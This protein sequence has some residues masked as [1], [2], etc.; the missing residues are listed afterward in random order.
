MKKILIILLS[1][2][3]LIGCKK[4]EKIE[5]DPEIAKY[6]MGLALEKAQEIYNLQQKYTCADISNLTI[7]YISERYAC[8]EYLFIHK[9]DL[10]SF[11]NLKK[12]YESRVK[13][14]W[15]AGGVLVTYQACASTDVER[16]IICQ[17]NKPTIMIKQ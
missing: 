7:Q 5:K 1:S 16:E 4:D 17:D 8:R 15:D 13:K 2:I 6:W 10:K 11:E 3:V 9:N 14:S 12:E